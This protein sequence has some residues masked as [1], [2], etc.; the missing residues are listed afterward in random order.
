[1]V[2]LL[3]LTSDREGL[4]NVILEALA[5]GVPAVATNV[6][7]VGE[8]LADGVTGY[9]VPPRDLS[10]LVNRVIGM[11]DDK[12]FRAECGRRGREYV[13]SHFSISAMVDRTVALYNSI[14]RSRGLPEIWPV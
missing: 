2:D 12:G 9:V 11:L 6:G 4:P 8:L 1:V 5:A 3:V 10:T 7:G 14:L 13:Q